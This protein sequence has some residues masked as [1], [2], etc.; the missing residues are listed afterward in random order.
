MSSSSL[1]SAQ[2]W[3]ASRWIILLIA[4]KSIHGVAASL[5]AAALN[6]LCRL[7]EW[8]ESNLYAPVQRRM[9]PECPS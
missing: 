7:W 2:T 4:G 5:L 6:R 8:Q 1:E 9:A 3:R